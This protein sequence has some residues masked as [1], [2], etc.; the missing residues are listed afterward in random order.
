MRKTGWLKTVL[1]TIIIA[2]TMSSAAFAV[3]T[4]TGTLVYGGMSYQVTGYWKENKT[5][6]IT[7]FVTDSV[8]VRKGWLTIG[9]YTY[10]LKGKGKRCTGTVLIGGNYYY[11]DKEGKQRTGLIDT[12]DGTYYFDPAQ[13]GARASGPGSRVINGVTYMF[14]SL[15][16]VL[17]NA[18]DDEG[19]YYDAKGSKIYKGTIKRLIQTALMPVGSTMYV[20]G[21]GWNQIEDGKGIESTTIGLSSRWATF[22]RSQTKDYNYNNTRY[23]MHDGLDCSGYVGWVLYNTFNKESGHGGYVMLAEI[24]AS[25]YAKWGWGTYTAS[26][27]VRDFQCGD[28]MS[29]SGGHVYIVIGQCTDGSLVLL[30]SSPKGVMISGTY[31]RAGGKNSE[32]VALATKYMKTFYPEWYAKYPDVARGTSYLTSYSQMRWNLGGGK[33][34]VMTDPDGYTNMGPEEILRDL[35]NK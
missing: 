22:F 5:K 7:K 31:T 35:F 23:Q 25:T 12:G 29:Y 14:N 21:G 13:N 1:L 17:I 15:G 2:V 28:I 32:A 11:F 3:E 18:F 20:W 8:A 16:Q 9:G 19:N 24:M 33:G 26:G 30:H 10:Y 34:S 6:G 27:S 4:M